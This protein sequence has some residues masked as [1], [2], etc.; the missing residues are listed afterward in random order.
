[1]RIVI[2]SLARSELICGLLTS[3]QTHS[4]S[5]PIDIFIIDPEYEEYEK[6]VMKYPGLNISIVV[7]KLGL[8]NQ[9]NFIRDF[10]PEGE[11][12]IISD[13]DAI[14]KSDI[15]QCSTEIFNNM[16]QHK[17]LLT[18]IS[19][20][21]NPYFN[22]NRT[23]DGDSLIKWT[24]GL[25]FCYG[26]FYWEINSKDPKLYLELKND[27]LEDYHRSIQHFFYS[28]AVGRYWPVIVKHNMFKPGGMQTNLDYP[29]RI[30]NHN[31]AVG[32]F[33]ARYK[34][35]CYTKSRNHI[36]QIVFKS[37]YKSEIWA[38][39][40]LSPLKNG[41][42][43][44]TCNTNLKKVSQNT[45]KIIWDTSPNTG[46][47]IAIVVP[48]I[49]NIIPR[50]T[51][52]A[53]ELLRVASNKKNM[54][55]GDIAGRVEMDRLPD[56]AKKHLEDK[57]YKLNEAGTRILLDG[58]GFDMSNLFRSYT[59]GYTTRKSGVG[60]LSSFDRK[61]TDRINTHLSQFFQDM[62]R[63]YNNFYLR[64]LE[65]YQEPENKYLETHFTAVTVNNGGRAA[66]HTDKY[67]RNFCAQLVLNHSKGAEYTGGDLIFP[68]YNLV[69]ENNQYNPSLVLFDSSVVRHCVSEIKKVNPDDTREPSRMSLIFFQK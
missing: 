42:Y 27:E 35:F 36:D 37:L 59:L 40:C 69:I 48:E 26:C 60:T 21:D 28:G 23:Q 2:P 16:R 11:E 61:N 47:I 45:I 20:T 32:D 38:D 39:Y 22:R 24:T 64:N 34:F 18:G 14:I 50:P 12:L 7:G 44:D 46:K 4:P 55:R 30:T 57:D 25:Y 65:N 41:M 62:S 53:I 68:D 49:F 13:D 10:Y 3:I 17:I 5:I 19:P 56:F 63:M 6:T 33:Y 51:T 9:R 58:D 8:V 15:T 66:I 31:L 29:G 67:N 54:N 1:M 43:M 52:E